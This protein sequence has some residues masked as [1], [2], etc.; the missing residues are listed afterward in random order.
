MLKSTRSNPDQDSDS[1][2]RIMADQNMNVRPI[3]DLKILNKVE[4][5]QGDEKSWMRFKE[6][7]EAAMGLIDLDDLLRTA[8]ANVTTLGL[9]GQT[10]ETIFK[11]KIIYLTLKQLIR[12]GKALT[13]LK[14]AERNNGFES[15][16]KISQA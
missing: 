16:R 10:A 2:S 7:Y 1:E 15:W 12:A 3:V 9:E 11:S 8:A 5:W 14:A 4:D 13:L 6:S